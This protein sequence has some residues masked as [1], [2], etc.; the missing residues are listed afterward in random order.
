[1]SVRHAHTS[2]VVVPSVYLKMRGQLKIGCARHHVACQDKVCPLWQKIPLYPASLGPPDQ[3]LS[4]RFVLYKCRAASSA[5]PR[6]RASATSS[7]VE[8]AHELRHPSPCHRTG[9]PADG[10]RAEEASE[11]QGRRGNS[12]GDFI[13]TT[14]DSSTAVWKSVSAHSQQIMWN[15]TKLYSYLVS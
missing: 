15:M 4:Q 11:Q 12:G 2:R 3:R 13:Y 7:M 8:V 1:M 5:R 14:T 9:R 10:K 6:L